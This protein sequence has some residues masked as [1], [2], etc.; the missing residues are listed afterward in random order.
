MAGTEGRRRLDLEADAMAWHPRAVVR[1]VHHKA[2]GGDRPQPDQAVLHPVARRHLMHPHRDVL[3][4]EVGLREDCAQL[5][6]ARTPVEVH[7]DLPASI[8]LF[9]RRAGGFGRVEAL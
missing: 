4:D 9:E 7:V 8:A 6:W 5:D 3:G 2:A 1:A